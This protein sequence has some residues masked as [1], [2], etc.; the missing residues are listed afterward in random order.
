MAQNPKTA[1]SNRHGNISTVSVPKDKALSPASGP[2]P[3]V[4]GQTVSKSASAVPD[5]PAAPRAP[6]PK[7]NEPL[8]VK[9]LPAAQPSAQSLPPETMQ[10]GKPVSSVVVKKGDSVNKLLLD[11]Y[12]RVD[13]TTLDSFK[14]LNPQIKNLNKIEAGKKIFLPPIAP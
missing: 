1:A 12:G 3:S 13:E 10:N 14:N 6:L 4:G 5:A 11:I 8:P 9:P 2:K 7:T